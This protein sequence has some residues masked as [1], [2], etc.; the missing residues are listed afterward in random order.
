[1]ILLN[2]GKSKVE[3]TN[4]FLT[5]NL[6]IKTII[7]DESVFSELQPIVSIKQKMT[8]GVEAL[9]RGYIQDKRNIITPNILFKSA[10]EQ[11]MLLELERLCRRVSLTQFEKLYNKNIV[12]STMMQLTSITEQWD[13]P[14]FSIPRINEEMV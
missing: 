7:Q 2:I 11:D 10:E 4:V 8:I 3:K 5:N 14:L 12:V 1:M 13:S 9:C 6:D